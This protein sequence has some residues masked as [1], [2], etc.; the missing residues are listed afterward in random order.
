MSATEAQS[1]ATSCVVRH[2]WA[3]PGAH[4]HGAE[5]PLSQTARTIGRPVARRARA[6]VV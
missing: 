1:S 2:S 3:M 6:I 4:A 5:T